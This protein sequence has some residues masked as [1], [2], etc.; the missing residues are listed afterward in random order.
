M[1][2]NYFK[3]LALGLLAAMMTACAGSKP[4]GSVKLGKPYNVAGKRYV[5]SY[6][7]N[8]DEVGMASWYGPGFHGRYTAN[9]ERF[10]QSDMTAAHATLPMPSMVRVTNL[11]NGKSTIVRI[12]DRGPFVGN[13]IIDLSEGAAKKIGLKQAGVGQVR[14]QYLPEDTERYIAGLSSESA[15]DAYAEIKGG[16]QEEL[17]EDSGK[18]NRNAEALLAQVTNRH[19][20]TA[21]PL[22]AVDTAELPAVKGAKLSAHY[23]QDAAPAEPAEIAPLPALAASPSEKSA[24]PMLLS[25]PTLIS[26]ANADEIKNGPFEVKRYASLSPASAKPAKSNVA[27]AE[28][29]VSPAGLF[30]QVGAFG[31]EENARSLAQKLNQIGTPEVTPVTIN[32][33]TW[34]RVRV[35]PAA[36]HSQANEM[37]EQI[38]ALGLKDARIIH[39]AGGI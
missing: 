10:D 2:P 22:A 1:R 30:I 35:G 19:T 16:D 15:R 28:K 18:R 21:A 3:F 20:T 33:Q 38:V 26:D 5:P 9:G 37:L 12:N 14:V 36:D 17:A 29:L 23:T 31:R 27:S 39:T 6:Q 7:P 4:P 11:R 34:Y 24:S 25:R 32:A 8:Y 13:R